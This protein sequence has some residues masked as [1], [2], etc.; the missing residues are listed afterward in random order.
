LAKTNA[1]FYM[2]RTPSVKDWNP[3][4]APLPANHVLLNPDRGDKQI[5]PELDFDLV[6]SQNKFGQFQLAKQVASVHHLPLVSLEH[7]LP[8][9]SWSP[10]QVEQL[11]G[12]R[13]D[14]NVF[15]SE[16]S[17]EAWGWGADE[18]QVVHH[19]IDT[20]R[21]KPLD[22]VV[23]KKSHLLSVVNDW[24][25]RDWCCGFKLWKQVTNGL[26][27]FVVGATPG[28]SEPARSVAELVNRYR[29]STVFVNTSLISPVPTALLEAM[30]CGCAVVSTANC[31]I[32]EIIENGVNG[33]LSN[34]P[35]E[36]AGYCRMLLEDAGLCRKLG[37]AARKTV[38]ERFSMGKFVENWNRVLEEAAQVIYR[39]ES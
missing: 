36:L 32:L 26:P 6:L 3:I 35:A 37:Q 7:T 4:Y 5:P 9:S 15:I 11:K 20:D 34:D 17:R 19:G 14:I 13:G 2:V 33:F 30:S 22:A 23:T 28:L 10:A 16:F 8:H 1:V 24:M 38:V 29:E 27:T 31:M 25:N 21:F 18:A 12:M 39:S